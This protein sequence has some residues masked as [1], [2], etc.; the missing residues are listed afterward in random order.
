MKD[1]RTRLG[2]KAEHAVDFETGA[3]VAVTIQPADQGDT[4]TVKQTLI[5]AA[6]NI[7]QVKPQSHGVPKLIA[8]KAY[9]SNDLLRI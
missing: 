5:T 8:H 9:H 7:E 6:E 2:H 3:V 4:E 1:G